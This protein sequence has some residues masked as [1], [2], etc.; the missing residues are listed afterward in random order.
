MLK[1]K[2]K[3]LF[4]L[5]SN[6]PDKEKGAIP[7]IPIIIVAA[8]G[9]FVSP[10]FLS[11]ASKDFGMV[12]ASMLVALSRGIFSIVSDASTGMINRMLRP[13]WRIINDQFFSSGW[14]ITRDV[15][16]LF[17]VLAIIAI[18]IATILRFKDYEA[19]K[20]LPL[21]IAV[22][23]LVN[24][25]GVVCGIVI[26]ASN[27]LMSGFNNGDYVAKT[28][29]DRLSQGEHDTLDPLYTDS[30]KFLDYTAKAVAYILAYSVLSIA[31]F[32]YFILLLVR[33]VMLGILYILSPM[34]FVLWIF[35][36]TKN[37]STKWFTNFIQWSFLGAMAAFFIH[38]ADQVLTTF[39][40]AG[41]ITV[42]TVAILVIVGLRM[43]YKTSAIG[44][45]AIIG[46]GAAAFTGGAALLW[47]EGKQL[48]GGAAKVTGISG[49]AQRA[50]E[51]VVDRATRIAEK[52]PILRNWIPPGTANVRQQARLAK[53]SAA[54]ETATLTP[55]QRQKI[56]TGTAVTEAQK[57]RQVEAI[58]QM[59]K[60][61]EINNIQDPVL[62]KKLLDK[63]AYH[64]GKTE[65]FSQ[66]GPNM[67]KDDKDAV[68]EAKRKL[69]GQDS[70]KTD[71]N[72]GAKIIYT[73]SDMNNKRSAGYIHM[74]S[75]AER[76][77]TDRAYAKMDLPAMREMSFSNPDDLMGLVANSGAKKLGK[78]REGLS[79]DKEA[80]LKAL[81][82]RIQKEEQAARDA[83]N[84]ARANALENA[85]LEIDAW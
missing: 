54:K 53:D 68:A 25:S 80:K 17:I 3:N 40:G 58:K 13:E 36:K 43:S 71:T 30:E 59:V 83:G 11:K 33:Y 85:W 18:A 28:M 63:V 74:Q 37:L 62:R 22:A 19:K 73:T 12:I 67:A 82:P 5:P 8:I 66:A 23:L 42:F 52:T 77:V 46:L 57:N 1:N 32:T 29:Y 78:A 35:P 26:D 16:N 10:A 79:S 70:G 50:K 15:A 7:L 45:G 60:E 14:I 4:S 44:A 65:I 2:L 31:F 38:L 51:A 41:T 84:I 75:E 55:E 39:S 34:A 47:K 72:T 61:H 9:Y 20:L 24:F 76:T 64:E 48:G 49:V 21:L 56:A 69:V 27:I 6:D 81:L